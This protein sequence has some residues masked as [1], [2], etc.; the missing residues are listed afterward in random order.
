MKTFLKSFTDGV[1][2]AII[3]VYLY[4]VYFWF[5]T[6][7]IPV[8]V[9]VYLL[10]TYTVWC[11]GRAYIKLYRERWI[12]DPCITADAA[13]HNTQ[14]AKRNFDTVANKYL[15][16]MCE[17]YIKPQWKRGK[18]ST[19]FTPSDLS[20]EIDDMYFQD[21]PDDLIKGKLE[22]LGY[23][24]IIETP[25]DDALKEHYGDRLPS[26]VRDN[27]VEFQ[28]YLCTHSKWRISWLN[29]ALKKD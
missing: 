21:L 1:I 15:N 9:V 24:V 23:T 26:M 13:Y 4:A 12:E 14:L 28:T 16:E 22:K 19:S 3:A 2:T 7:Q 27:P 8:D 29:Q 11:T 17:W 18:T 5:R 10:A 25:T 6:E 20:S